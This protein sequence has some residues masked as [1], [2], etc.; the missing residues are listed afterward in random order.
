[1][2]LDEP[3]A[4]L[5]HQTAHWVWHQIAALSNTT[6]MIVITHD[7]IPDYFH[8]ICDDPASKDDR[9]I[10]ENHYLSHD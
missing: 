9:F 6:V 4:A 8:L 10:I 5:D 7:V 2:I 1:M 3:T